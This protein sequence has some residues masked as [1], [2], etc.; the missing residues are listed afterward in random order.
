[1]TWEW[2]A[3]IAIAAVWTL[4]LQ[5]IHTWNQH[6]QIRYARNLGRVPE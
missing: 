5:L 1:M 3:L 2:V 4:G 6:Q